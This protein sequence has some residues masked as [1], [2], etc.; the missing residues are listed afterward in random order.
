MQGQ[1][2]RCF[3]DEIYISRRK[4]Q[5][6]LKHPMQ[7]VNG[8]VEKGLFCHIFATIGAKSRLLVVVDRLLRLDLLTATEPSAMLYPVALN[9]AIRLG[10]LEFAA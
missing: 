9:S 5:K 8:S 3:V 6:V 2:C 1:K 4:E 10:G 7:A